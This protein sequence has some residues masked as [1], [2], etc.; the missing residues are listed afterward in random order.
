MQ[1]Y[2]GHGDFDRRDA[3]QIAKEFE[4]RLR[5]KELFFIDLMQVDEI[6]HYYLDIQEF[7]KALELVRFASR[8]Y[9][10]SADL[11]AKK[12][13]IFLEMG[14]PSTALDE[15]ETALSLAPYLEEL[16]IFKADLLAQLDRYPEA[17]RTL[18]GMLGT[19]EMP[20]EIFLHMGNIAQMSGQIAE[21]ER[22]YLK[23]LNPETGFIEPLYELAFLYEGEQ[24]FADAIQLYQSYLDQ[25]PY[26]EGVWYHLS[27]LHRK[28]GNA[29]LALDAVEYALAVRDDFHPAW[30]QKGQIMLEMGREYEALQAFLE[31]GNLQPKDPQTQYQ[32]GEAFERLEAYTDAIRHY[33]KASRQDPEYL[34]AIMG[35][36][37]CLEKQGR[38]MEAL[39]YYEK[40]FRLDDEHPELCFCLAVCEY[41]L[42]HRYR[43]YQYLDR[44][45]KLTPEEVV[46]WQ[47]WAQ[48]LYDHKNAEG[49]IVYLTEAIR[50]HPT[51]A[52]LYYQAA[53]YSFHTGDEAQGLEL[54]ENGLLVDAGKHYL[55]FHI[56]P[57]LRKNAAVTRLIC[58]YK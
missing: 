41:K 35:V 1:D 47:D 29:I 30:I 55:L 53:A 40:A 57:E 56:A 32:I 15:L 34:D 6:F 18:E 37:F 20:E 12:A 14:H 43:S 17:I 10:S 11:Y 28:T 48:L 3:G 4:Q 54:L 19:A 33:H 8:S 24:R 26:S 50:H 51:E 45:L 5:S 36:G 52:D 2:L 22:F 9:P 46:Y 7:Q 21:S 25:Q 16:L 27:L 31:A 23:A 38:F 44:C 39:N 49:A 58:Q 42:G 13:R